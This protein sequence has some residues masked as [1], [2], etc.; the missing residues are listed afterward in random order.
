MIEIFNSLLSNYKSKIRNPFFGTLASVWLIR[1]WSIVYAIFNFDKNCSMQDKINY[2]QDYF[3]HKEFSWELYHNLWVSFAVLGFTYILLAFSRAITDLYYKWLEPFIITKID[4]KAIYTT[5]EKMRLEGRISLLDKKLI[6]SESDLANHIIEIDKANKE[7]SNL[8][9]DKNSEIEKLKKS[10]NEQTK[11]NKISALTFHDLQEYFDNLNLP[12]SQMQL[13][14][15]FEN[16]EIK[17]IVSPGNNAQAYLRLINAGLVS[18]NEKYIEL[19]ILGKIYLNM[20]N[21]NKTS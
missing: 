14:E 10:I 2:I 20:R 19:T 13:I 3:S 15:N 21:Y 11:L 5:P 7:Y 16:K 12:T 9:T 8:S 18:N 6:K 1:N 17:R 4:K